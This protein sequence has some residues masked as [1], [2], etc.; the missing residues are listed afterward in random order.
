[1]RTQLNSSH[2]HLLHLLA[3]GY[4]DGEIAHEMALSPDQ[5][6]CAFSDVCRQLQVP[7]RIELLLMLWSSGGVKKIR[8]SKRRSG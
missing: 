5:L 7:D 8:V 6:H 3:L 1:M 2:R 4:T